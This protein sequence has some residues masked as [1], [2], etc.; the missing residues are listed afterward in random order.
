MNKHAIR[1]AMLGR[2]RFD[3]HPGTFWPSQVRFGQ[4]AFGRGYVL[5]RYPANHHHRNHSSTHP[6]PPPPPSSLS[7]SMVSAEMNLVGHY[8]T[9]RGLRTVNPEGLPSITSKA[10]VTQDGD[11][12][13]LGNPTNRRVVARYQKNVPLC[14]C[15]RDRAALARRSDAQP[16]WDQLCFHCDLC[17]STTL[18]PRPH[19]ALD[20]R[21]VPPSAT[22]QRCYYDIGDPP[23]C[24]AW[25]LPSRL[26]RTYGV[27]T[28]ILRR[29]SVFHCKFGSIP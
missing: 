12:G 22:L 25:T 5:T 24:A 11:H 17:A 4:G 7:F 10:P 9:L 18:I 28:T 1:Y 8:R 26:L 16:L 23:H 20:M 14:D 6:R 19:G 15:N 3:V 27:R 29:P 13:D 2:V 21:S